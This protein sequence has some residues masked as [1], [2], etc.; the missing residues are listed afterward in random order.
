MSLQDNMFFQILEEVEGQTNDPNLIRSK[1]SRF[2]L[3]KALGT[4]WYERCVVFRTIQA[5]GCS[6]EAGV[7]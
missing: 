4:T 5:H 1:V 2:F 6:M 3:A 7:G